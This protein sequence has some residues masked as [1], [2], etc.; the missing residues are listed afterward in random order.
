MPVAGTT[1]TTT[2]TSPGT[3]TTAPSAAGGTTTTTA[4]T[5]T[6]SALAVVRE[7]GL[8]QGQGG[9]KPLLLR[10][11]DSS[12]SL[13]NVKVGAIVDTAGG[14]RGLAPQGIPIGVI[15]RIVAQSADSSEIVEVTPNASLQQLNFVAVV[16]YVPNDDA[17]GP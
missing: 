4:A 16:L 8:L 13:T 9:N 17:V 1:T 10:F 3:T 11:V 5:T 6:T 7:T 2:T 15:T 12:S 14:I